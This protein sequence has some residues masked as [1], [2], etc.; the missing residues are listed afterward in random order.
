MPCLW[1]C[2]QER[3]LTTSI[4]KVTLLTVQPRQQARMRGQPLERLAVRILALQ[5]HSLLLLP[6]QVLTTRSQQNITCLMQWQCQ[7]ATCSKWRHIQCTRKLSLRVPCKLLTA[8][9]VRHGLTTREPF[10]CAAA[11]CCLFVCACR[12]SGTAAAAGCSWCGW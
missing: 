6:P 10:F 9:Y 2:V 3:R 5:R 8:C 4:L 7:E 12:T 1:M 11:C